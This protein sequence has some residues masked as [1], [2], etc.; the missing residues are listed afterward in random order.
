[1]PR[2]FS[3]ETPEA[4]TAELLTA[5]LLSFVRSRALRLRLIPTMEA[6]ITSNPDAEG[7]L[8][9]GMSF[10]QVSPSVQEGSYHS[11]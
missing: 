2:L 8:N 6:V 5:K 3:Q 1:M 10:N 9:L 7:N 4:Q 11:F